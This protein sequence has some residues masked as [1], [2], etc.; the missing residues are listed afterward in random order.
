[1]SEDKVTGLDAIQAY[2]MKKLIEGTT[3]LMGERPMPTMAKA[4][5]WRD[6]TKQLL[7]PLD[8]GAED[9]ATWSIDTN[10]L[11]RI[12]RDCLR[13]FK[14]GGE[15]ADVHGYYYSLNALAI[16]LHGVATFASKEI[17]PANEALIEAN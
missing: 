9:K 8:T 15:S 6:T 11:D 1:M 4:N 5:T 16:A 13:A 2:M 14:N 12:T 10:M 17:S 7:A 3:P